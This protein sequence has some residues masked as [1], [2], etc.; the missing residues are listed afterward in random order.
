MV[1]RLTVY[2]RNADGN[3]MSSSRLRDGALSMAVGS[4]STMG[5]LISQLAA[6]PPSA[7]DSSPLPQSFLYPVACAGVTVT[8]SFGHRAPH[9]EQTARSMNAWTR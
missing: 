8:L 6:S 1:R 7:P 4:S 3:L 2:Q 9:L 5:M